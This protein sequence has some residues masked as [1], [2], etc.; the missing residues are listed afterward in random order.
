MSKIG[1]SCLTF[2]NIRQILVGIVID[3][4]VFWTNFIYTLKTKFSRNFQSF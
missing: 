1:V 3:T 4:K 2:A